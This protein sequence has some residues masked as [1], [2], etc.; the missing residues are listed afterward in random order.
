MGMSGSQ[1]RLLMLTSRLH[2]VELKAQNIL[3]QKLAL[4]TQRD[5]L[6]KDYCDALD[7]TTIG[8]TYRDDMLNNKVIDANYSSLCEYNE[9]RIMQYA[10]KDNKSGLMIVSNEVKENYDLYGGDK[11]KFAHAM[12]D[13][14]P[15]ISWAVESDEP[16]D[17]EEE[18]INPEDNYD[19]DFEYIEEHYGDDENFDINEDFLKYYLED[20]EEI[21]SEETTE[22][23]EETQGEIVVSN[24]TNEFNFYLNLWD[25]IDKA[26]GCKV[27]EDEYKSGNK[28]TEWLNNMVESGLVSIQVWDL[29]NN[30]KEWSET[31]V[32]TSFNANYL[33]TVEDEEA[34]KKA[35]R[36]YEYNLDLLKSK[37]T[38]FDT[39]LSKLET[40][41]TSISTE[42][43]SLKKVRDDNIDRTFKIFS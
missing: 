10:L 38:K 17:T 11:Y 18:T 21:P 36:E 1:A 42:M 2:D 12:V 40:E 37:E 20:G 39:D 5:D 4:S 43:E 8:V 16:A 24:A 15:S 34:I 27:I 9:N 31:S 28:G 32:A 29:N 26:G 6:Y 30:G 22:A 7:A 14:D 19:F 13:F 23:E 41:K 35:E 25:A 33:S 3:A